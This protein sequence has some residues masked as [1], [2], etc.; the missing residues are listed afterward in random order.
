MNLQAEMLR[1]L[2]RRQDIISRQLS[3]EE[4]LAYC[5]G[6]VDGSQHIVDKVKRE[7]RL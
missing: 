5:Y 4:K 1:L 6:F 2:E 7:M 3:V